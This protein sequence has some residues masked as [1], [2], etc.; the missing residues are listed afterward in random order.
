MRERPNKTRLGTIAQIEERV[1]TVVGPSGVVRAFITDLLRC[2]RGACCSARS[3]RQ[4]VQQCLGLQNAMTSS[5]E[6]M[7]AEA[8]GYRIERS[9][10][11]C[12]PPLEGV[13]MQSISVLEQI[14]G[15]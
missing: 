5:R 1:D 3:R 10:M 14:L 4:T 7:S 15:C 6:P 11:D 9:L 12:V 2:V 8:G 13:A